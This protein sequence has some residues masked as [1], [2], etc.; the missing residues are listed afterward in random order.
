VTPFD[1]ADLERLRT[2]LRERL[3]LQ[4]ETGT[5]D[6]LAETLVERMRESGCDRFATYWQRLASRAT[7][8]PELRAL[9]ESVTVGETYFFRN[10]DQLAA[11]ARAALPETV[12]AR[13][14]RRSLRILSAGCASGEEA[15]TLAI[16]VSEHL[17]DFASW[18]VS[19]S[20]ID[21]NASSLE[22]ARLARYSPWSLRQLPE[23]VRERYFKPFGRELALDERVR[24]MV[25]WEE[26]NLLDD[27]PAFWKRGSFDV[28][29]FRNVS[30]YLT[31]EATRAVVAK[32]AHALAPGGYLFLGDA[33]TLRSV[34]REFHLRNTHGAF[35]YQLREGSERLAS[36]GQAPLDTGSI[37]AL[38]VALA[39]TGTSWIEA[40]RSASER[41]AALE[42]NPAPRA[43]SAAVPRR[44]WDLERAT[45]LVRRERFTEALQ[46][47]RELPFEA[48]AD[49]QAQLLRAVVLTNRGD[50]AGAEAVCGG[51]LARD[52]LNAEAHYLKALCRERAGDRAAA[53][54]HDRTAAYL[55]PT[56]AMPHLHLGLL[57]KRAGDA[58]GTR[59]MIGRALEL[60]ERESS[61]RILLF[62]GG[63][64]R[65]A[66][67]LLCHAELRVH[68]GAP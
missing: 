44:P 50:V 36:R 61:S 24:G 13:S 1:S 62:G 66:L 34:S 37:E 68:G 28:I 21:V 11:F 38:P 16:L 42:E 47:L 12:R 65:E 17:Q 18:N 3:G 63:F 40:I 9:V 45:E 8:L 27:D 20:G 59:A 7:A 32:I 5:R 57:A 43:A 58:E 10:Q 52:E 60:L 4:L 23:A 49:P 22:K 19:I 14:P 54:E 53:A 55:D 46:A 6:G 64:N 41:I 2:L 29:F 30:I 31:P 48:E 26:R 25:A 51:V 56:F 15:Y 35:Y 33:E 39:E 67:V